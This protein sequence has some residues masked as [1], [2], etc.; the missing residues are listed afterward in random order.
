[1]E[2]EEAPLCGVCKHHHHQGTKCDVCG[3]VGKCHIYPK[4]K[5]RATDLRGLKFSF[6]D[7]GYIEANGQWDILCEMRKMVYCTEM[8]IP[9]DQEFVAAE[10]AQ[11]RHMIGYAGDAPV[12]F[13]RYHPENIEGVNIVVV[14]RLGVLANYRG[15]G[16]CSQCVPSLL[17]DIQTT[18]QGAVTSVIF[19]TPADSTIKVKAE[20]L[21]GILVSSLMPISRGACVFVGVSMPGER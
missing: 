13:A 19:H 21:G 9:T 15:R 5:M 18:Y 2:L 14:D 1:M 20:S 4:M 11:S 3:H 10:E 7:A 6:Y 16:I 8:G 12:A 17:S